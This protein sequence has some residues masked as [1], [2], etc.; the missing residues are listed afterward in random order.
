MLMPA[1]EKRSFTCRQHARH[2]AVDVQQPERPV[3]AGSATSG[4]F[5][6]DTVEPLSL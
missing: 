3:C 2:V 5:T 6:A 4:K 1:A